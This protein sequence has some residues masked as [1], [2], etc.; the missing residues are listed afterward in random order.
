M[1]KNWVLISVSLS[2]IGFIMGCVTGVTG[3]KPK[4]EFSDKNGT[5]RFFEVKELETIPAISNAFAD[6]RYEYMTLYEA[7]KWPDI[8]PGHTVTEGFVC[9]RRGPKH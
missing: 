9:S 4:V 2:A 8:I 3:G 1:K 5:A 6:Y 7:A